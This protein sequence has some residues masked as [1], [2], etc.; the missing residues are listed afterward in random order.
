MFFKDKVSLQVISSSND[1]FALDIAFA[2]P[3][4]FAIKVYTKDIH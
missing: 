4:E 2:T 1:L 3:V